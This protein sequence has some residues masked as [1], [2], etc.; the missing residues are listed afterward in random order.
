MRECSSLVS[1][2]YNS[3][4][5]SSHPYYANDEYQIQGLD[6]EDDS[7]YLVLK[8]ILRYEG[9]PSLKLKHPLEDFNS[10]AEVKISIAT[11]FNGQIIGHGLYIETSAQNVLELINN[12]CELSEIV[13][14][15]K[16]KKHDVML[17]L[18]SAG[19]TKQVQNSIMSTYINQFS[20][21]KELSYLFFSICDERFIKKLNTI[22]LKA[23]KIRNIEFNDTMITI[24][25]FLLSRSELMAN[26]FLLRLAVISPKRLVNFLANDRQGG[27][28]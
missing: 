13:T 14:S 4:I 27:C 12:N 7:F 25:S 9:N 21:R 26:R 8:M 24:H 16:H 19:A 28:K 22:K 10:L 2:S 17:V 1:P 5:K 20:E 6:I 3:A 18:S 11:A 23:F 15:C